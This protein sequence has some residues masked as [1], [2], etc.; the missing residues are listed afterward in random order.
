M[1][2]GS[3]VIQRVASRED[4][5]RERERERER[6]EKGGEKVEAEG[7]RVSEYPNRSSQIRAEGV[8]Y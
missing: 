1:E 8:T 7:D 6:E 5:Q 4:K 2:T 3:K